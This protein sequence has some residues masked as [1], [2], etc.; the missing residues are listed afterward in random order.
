MRAGA[1]TGRG[2]AVALLLNESQATADVSLLAQQKLPTATLSSD[3][4]INLKMFVWSLVNF[5]FL[6]FLT[7]FGLTRLIY[8]RK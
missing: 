6:L 1:K 3:K 7:V 5:L 4:L 8:L 2:G